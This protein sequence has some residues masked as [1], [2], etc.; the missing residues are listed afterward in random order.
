[1]ELGTRIDAE[2]SRE[3]VSNHEPS[4][5]PKDPTMRGVRRELGSV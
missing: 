4:Y 5:F 2:L 3:I 1:M